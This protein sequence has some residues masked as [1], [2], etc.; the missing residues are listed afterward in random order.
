MMRGRYHMVTSEGDAFEVAVPQF[1][2]DL[3]DARTKLN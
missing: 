1:S 3:P 2:L